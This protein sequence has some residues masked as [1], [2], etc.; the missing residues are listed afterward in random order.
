MNKNKTQRL[1][2]PNT[3]PYLFFL[4]V[5]AVATLLI[6]T[7]YNL[8]LAA[9]E[10]VAILALL[11]Y[12]Y[13]NRRRKGRA[14]KAYIDSVTYDTE[15]AKNHTLMNFPLPIVVF[16]LDDSRI[17]WGNDKF[18]SICGEKATHTDT[19]VAELIPSFSGKW[20]VE[21]K[22]QCPEVVDVGGRK[23]QIYGNIVRPSSEESGTRTLMGIAYWMDIT[24]YDDLRKEYEASHPVAA[25]FVIDNFE[26]LMKNQPERIRNDLRDEIGDKLQQWCEDKHGVLR[27]F[28]RDRYMFL[29]E[30][31]YMNKVQEGK[32][33]ILQIVH[34]VVSP[35][36]IHATL[37]IGVGRGA[38]DFTETLQFAELSVEMA[39][40]RGGDQAVI[41]NRFNFEF[42][43][44][45]AGEIETRT[46]VKSRVMANAIAVLIKDAS[47]VLVMGHRFSDMD[48]IGAS[49]A[50][51]AIARKF[52]V[53]AHIV[54]DTEKSSAKPLIRK[55]QATPEYEHA[56][57]TPQ[58]AMLIADGRTL[59][60]VVDT[61]RPEQVEDIG[62]LQSCNKVTVIDHH[63]RAATY[64]DKA[65]L[66][67]VEPYA[68]SACELLTEVV[69]VIM[70]G[71]QLLRC[72]AEAILSG[73][74]LDTKSFSMRTG[75]RT[76]DAA[77]VL[78]RCGANT[79]EVK[80]LLQSD[81][82][83]SVARYK[84]MQKA[85]IYRG[86]AIAAPE[87]P[88][89][90]IV[91]AQA[92]DELLDIS[93]VEASMVM[94]PMDNGDVFVSARSI[95]EVNVQLIM[96]KLGGGGNRASAAAQIKNTSLKTALTSLKTAIDEYFDV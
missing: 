41:K 65:D 45:K 6:K 39:L 61:N 68:S 88:Q 77:A 85:G 66:S 71:R 83:Q 15:S 28:D 90:R 8:Y 12:S 92:A 81:V 5:F 49:V 59:L 24:E 70:E 3:R 87:T 29:F 21:G 1:L 80:K 54:A 95:G 26:E 38:A 96:E 79:T 57:V 30:E 64:I 11:I 47:R 33:S 14:L 53:S 58:E 94:Y 55:L 46:K 40:S 19:S 52:G 31:R 51:C 78:R 76:F 7:E 48:S 63:R 62:L 89:N 50:V 84:I 60:V 86:L 56:F 16:R 2:E 25:I 27:R 93:G 43:G 32:F 18:F 72:E 20:L 10:G 42:F 75:D 23:Y 35:S 34:D 91:A 82:E 44:G 13:I 69:E 36:G 17:I 74:V 73:I 9:A 67:F 22:T 37:S 4:L